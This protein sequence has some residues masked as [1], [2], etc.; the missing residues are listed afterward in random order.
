MS[1]VC[2]EHGLKGKQY[3]EGCLETIL[4]PNGGVSLL[5]PSVDDND[6]K[7]CVL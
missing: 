5:G 4:L 6:K 1:V 3:G 2:A 7:S